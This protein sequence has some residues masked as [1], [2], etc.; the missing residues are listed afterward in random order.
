MYLKADYEVMLYQNRYS[1]E[2]ILTN[3]EGTG[4]IYEELALYN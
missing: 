2:G 1:A 4:G 3:V